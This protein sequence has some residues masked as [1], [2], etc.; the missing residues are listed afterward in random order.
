M[1][2]EK[3]I[4]PQQQKVGYTWVMTE[5]HLEQKEAGVFC[6]DCEHDY[7]V[8]E[9]IL[10]KANT[11][12]KDK[13]AWFTAVNKEGSVMITRTVVRLAE[14][15]WKAG[16]TPL[17]AFRQQVM[18]HKAQLQA[19]GFEMWWK[20]Q[21]P[22]A[23]ADEKQVAEED[24]SAEKPSKRQATDNRAYCGARAQALMDAQQKL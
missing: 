5:T 1:L 3:E 16:E 21:Y 7:K 2:C 4:P 18:D 23:Q 14:P 6:E 20:I 13:N 17:V 15:M 9:T 11:I 8:V 24:T 19:I 10:W 12:A 22:D